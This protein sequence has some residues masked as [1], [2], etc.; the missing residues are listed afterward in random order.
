LTETL[1]LQDV[2]EKDGCGKIKKPGDKNSHSE[3]MLF[4]L[5]V[6]KR[7]Y[8]TDSFLNAAR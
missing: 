8:L 2:H 7:A 4:M 6:Y 3:K 1:I 5:F